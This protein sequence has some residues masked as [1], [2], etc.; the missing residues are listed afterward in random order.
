MIFHVY[1]LGRVSV[2]SCQYALELTFYLSWFLDRVKRMFGSLHANVT[3][4]IKSISM[5]PWNSVSAFDSFYIN[6]SDFGEV[7]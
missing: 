6:G 1:S 3:N 5:H 2:C 4:F 7:F